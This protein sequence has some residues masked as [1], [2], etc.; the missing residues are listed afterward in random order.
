MP[1]K[2]IVK[3]DQETGKLMVIYQDIEVC[4]SMYPDN[5]QRY[6]NALNRVLERVRNEQ[7]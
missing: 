6:C 4:Y 2:A 1:E 5:A 7:A 3:E